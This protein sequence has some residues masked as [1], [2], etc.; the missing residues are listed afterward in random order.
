MGFVI[1]QD[2]QN[3][4][5]GIRVVCCVEYSEICRYTHARACSTCTRVFLSCR[6]EPW[7]L[8]QGVTYETNFRLDN[9]NVWQLKW[10]SVSRNVEVS[11]HR[12][13]TEWCLNVGANYIPTDTGD[14]GSKPLIVF[15]RMY[16]FPIIKRINCGQELF[17]YKYLQTHRYRGSW[18]KAINGIQAYVFLSDH[19]KNKLW[20]RIIRIQIFTD[21]QIR[22]SLFKAING[23]QAYVFLS[24]G[25]QAYV[26]LSD[27]TKNKC[28]Q[29][30]FGYK[31]LQT[32]RYSGSWFKA[33]NGIQAYVFLS[34]HSKNKLWT[35]IIRIQI[36][37]NPQIRGSWFKA[38]NGI[39]AYVFLS[40]GIQAYVFLSD[41]TKNKLWTRIIRI[42]I[43]TGPQIQGKLFQSH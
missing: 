12:T 37:T 38:I 21:P 41:H 31:Y 23:I 5:T 25:I 35:R 33:I 9:H 10:N 27:H 29:E 40:N 17:G 28:G 36:F 22:G 16:L 1:K 20:T 19:S 6:N 30:L 4:S 43:F 24:N 39:Q 42:Q 8:L 15:R 3:F 13:H 32:H 26:F 34:D 2:Q 14:V 11:S 18:F 7:I